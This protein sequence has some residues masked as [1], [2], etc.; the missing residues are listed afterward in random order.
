MIHYLN[1]R[2]NKFGLD[3]ALLSQ[4]KETGRVLGSYSTDT[5]EDSERKAIIISELC[6]SDKLPGETWVC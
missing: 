6:C 4:C 2:K 3:I 1:I 5:A